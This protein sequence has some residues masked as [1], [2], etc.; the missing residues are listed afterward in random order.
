MVEQRKDTDSSARAASH[1]NLS[2]VVGVWA[3]RALIL[4]QVF[5]CGWVPMQT[6]AKTQGH[7]EP[8][9]R[10][11]TPV[12][13]N[14]SWNLFRSEALLESGRSD[15]LGTA[16]QRRWGRES[17]PKTA[18]KRAGM[19]EINREVVQQGPISTNQTINCNKKLHWCTPIQCSSPVHP[20][21]HQEFC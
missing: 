20:P 10:K 6:V 3:T 14:P 5:L 19:C 11:C 17:G 18:R 9:T 13:R 21:N 8:C 12:P 15:S 16:A 1:Q 4:V 2:L 7:T